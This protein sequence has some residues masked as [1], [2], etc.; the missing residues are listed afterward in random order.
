M[1]TD[2][3]ITSSEK[4]VTDTLNLATFQFSH[5]LTKITYDCTLKTDKT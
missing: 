3:L 5:D 1:A 2:T 4:L